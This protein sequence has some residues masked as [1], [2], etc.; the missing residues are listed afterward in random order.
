MCAQKHIRLHLFSPA[1][2][3]SSTLK[4]HIPTL[5]NAYENTR[6][7]LQLNCQ[8]RIRIH[9]FSHCTHYQKCY[10]KVCRATYTIYA[11]RSFVHRPEAGLCY[12]TH[13]NTPAPPSL[14]C[15]KRI[16]IHLFSHELNSLK[17]ASE[18]TALFTHVCS[19]A[20]AIER[21][22]HTLELC[23]LLR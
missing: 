16:R 21:A 17:N 7:H 15:Q 4:A 5:K 3:T 20:I 6:S 22:T 11:A 12:Q 1:L 8:K 14:N 18:Y 2:P 13:T 10:S 19:L 9:L 23:L